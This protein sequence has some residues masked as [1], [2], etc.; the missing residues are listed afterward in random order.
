MIVDIVRFDLLHIVVSLAISKTR[1]LWIG[2]S[3]TP[4]SVSHCPM[5]GSD[6]I[7]NISNSLIADIVM[8]HI[9]WEENKPPFIKG[10]K[11]FS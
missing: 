2:S 9:G 5:T 3:P 11:T 4:T 6:T 7:C 8:S 10:V 1:L